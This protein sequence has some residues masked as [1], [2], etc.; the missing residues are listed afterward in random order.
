MGE[1]GKYF[2]PS[3]IGWRQTHS[4]FR[5]FPMIILIIRELFMIDPQVAPRRGGAALRCVAA[6]VA[7]RPPASSSDQIFVLNFET[8]D[9][10][11]CQMTPF[12]IF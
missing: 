10:C 12:R 3:A 6:A 9:V 8:N 7:K 11:L 4:L 1:N 5:Y 2:G